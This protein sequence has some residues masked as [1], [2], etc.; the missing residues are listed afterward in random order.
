MNSLPKEVYK[1]YEMATKNKAKYAKEWRKVHHNNYQY[2]QFV[3]EYIRYKYPAMLNEIQQVYREIKD[4]NPTKRKL[5]KT[6]EFEIWKKNI[7]TTENVPEMNQNATDIP[8]TEN[9]PEIDQN[10]TDTTT[11][12]AEMDA[13]DIATTENVPEM[14]QNATDTTTTAAEMENIEVMESDFEIGATDTVGDPWLASPL[15]DEINKLIEELREDP[16]L[17]AIMNLVEQQL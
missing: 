10:A 11:T 4:R 9:V 2:G 6:L 13:M 3:V 1:R 7:P 12:A 16:D 17:R 15:E 5:Y 14:D 8:T